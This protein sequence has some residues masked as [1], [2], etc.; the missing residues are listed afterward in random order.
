MGPTSPERAAEAMQ[1]P[2]GAPGEES[3]L[4]WVEVVEEGAALEGS[5]STRGSKQA[6]ADD[7]EGIQGQTDLMLARGLSKSKQTALCFWLSELKEG[8]Q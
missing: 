7:Q 1:A 6:K 2:G 5:P 3:A 4:F 8:V